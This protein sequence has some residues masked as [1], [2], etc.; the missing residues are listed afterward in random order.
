[1]LDDAATS[2]AGLIGDARQRAIADGVRPIPT[3]VYRALLGYFPA[4]LLQ[5]C[6]F[7][8]GR[9]RALTVPQVA[10]SYGDATAI[11]LGDVVLFKTE[12]AADT[13]LKV[14]A[15][16][17][18][19]VMQCQRWGIDGFADH[20]VRDH[21]AVEQEAIDTADRFAAWL[22]RPDVPAGSH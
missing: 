4:G 14:W 17:L 20:Y 22:A 5:Q 16:E 11:A 21:S 1:M 2:L 18:T 15:H 3:P 8:A 10:L 6:R 19:H 12:Q 7:T 13:G 9:L